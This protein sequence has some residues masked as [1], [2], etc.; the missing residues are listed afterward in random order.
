[1]I[2]VENT[3]AFGFSAAIRGKDDEAAANDPK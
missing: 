1:M 3:A 2:K